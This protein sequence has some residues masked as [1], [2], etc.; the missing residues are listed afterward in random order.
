MGAHK[1]IQTLLPQGSNVCGKFLDH[2]SVHVIIGD[3]GGH[4]S[5]CQLSFLL[6]YDVYGGALVSL[7]PQQKFVMLGW[8]I[9]GVAIWVSINSAK[10][11]FPRVVSRAANFRTVLQ[12]ILYLGTV[13]VAIF[14]VDQ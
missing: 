1:V 5:F 3:C 4:P 2:P 10:H 8:L 14:P 6:G 12:S 9:V 11:F 7:H 13:E